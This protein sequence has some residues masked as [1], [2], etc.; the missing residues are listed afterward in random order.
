MGALAVNGVGG[1]R[2]S[3]GPVVPGAR[4]VPM[5]HRYR[6]LYCGDANACT[7][8]CYD[9]IERAFAFEGPEQI[10]A[11]STEPVLNAGDCIPPGSKDY[12]KKIRQLCD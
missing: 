8:V 9:E 11:I 4:Y 6:C 7:M 12:F 3:F 5:S 1:I 10:A 2:A